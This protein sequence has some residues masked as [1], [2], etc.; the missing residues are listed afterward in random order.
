MLVKTWRF[1]ALIL[2]SLSMALAFC[3]LLEMRPRL[4]WDAPLWIAATVTGNQF[5]LFGSV[6]AAI[7]TLAWIGAVV[8]AVLV[9]HR[10]PASFRLTITG[11]A[12]LVLAFLV[13]W[14]FVF[15]VNVEMTGWTPQQFASDWTAWRAQW[16]YAH[17]VRAVLL[18][19]GLSALLLSVVVET[20]EEPVPARRN[21]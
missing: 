9:R 19:L 16:E 10:Q 21:D 2:A 12:L 6:G 1:G 14:A 20:P 4:A 7:E 5:R 8:L 13:W 15:P 18:I 17:A 3:H 11:A